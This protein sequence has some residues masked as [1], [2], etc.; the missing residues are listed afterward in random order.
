MFM[1]CFCII[2]IAAFLCFQNY[3]GVFFET[4][5][6]QAETIEG[7][8]KEIDGLKVMTMVNGRDRGKDYIISTSWTLT[9]KG[10]ER[11][12]MKYQEKRKS[13]NYF[14]VLDVFNT[15]R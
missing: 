15:I 8:R 7:S 11:H 10:S 14:N 1:R 12:R 3:G 9:E 13:L 6:L 5:S 4:D 2:I